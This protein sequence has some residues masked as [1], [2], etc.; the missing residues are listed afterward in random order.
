MKKNVGAQD[1]HVRTIIAGVLV[2]VALLVVD[3]PYLRI[4]MAL[5]GAALAAT[6]YIRYCFLYKLLGKNTCE[7]EAVSPS[8]PHEE[9]TPTSSDEK[10]V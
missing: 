5:V 10:S 6:A 2:V 8:E 3:N 9:H 7:A 1:A 4:G